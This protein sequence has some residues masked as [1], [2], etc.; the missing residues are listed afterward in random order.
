MNIETETTE[1]APVYVAWKD[2]NKRM[3]T[4]WKSFVK[5]FPIVVGSNLLEGARVNFGRPNHQII[6]AEMSQFCQFLATEKSLQHPLWRV[7]HRGATLSLFDHI[8]QWF[9]ARVYDWNADFGLSSCK[10]I[11][12]DL[13]HIIERRLLGMDQHFVAMREYF[14]QSYREWMIHLAAL[15]LEEALIV[16]I[17]LALLAFQTV[18]TDEGELLTSP[19]LPESFASRVATRFPNLYASHIRGL[20]PAPL[21]LGRK[22]QIPGLVSPEKQT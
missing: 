11:C 5:K 18:L 3:L 4:T 15:E 8:F 19:T 10:Y 13:L 22:V 9:H 6:N 16:A 12:F 1:P 7:E 14:H 2:G 21:Y 20:F 17:V